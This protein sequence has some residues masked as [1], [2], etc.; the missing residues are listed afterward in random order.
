MRIEAEL[1]VARPVEEVFDYLA[2]ITNEAKWNPWAN[3]VTK[4]GDGPVGPGAVF[5]GSYK[6]SASSTRTC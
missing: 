3:W 2:D 4:T 5:R 6:G 1:E